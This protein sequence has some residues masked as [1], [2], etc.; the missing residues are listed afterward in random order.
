MLTTGRSTSGNSRRERR[1]TAP[2]PRMSSSS[3]ITV[4]KTGRRTERSEIIMRRISVA[5]RRGRG[6]RLVRTLFERR[7]AVGGRQRPI[8]DA[9]DGA[10]RGAVAHLLRAFDDHLF[11][12]FH[13]GEDL[14]GA[15]L[16]A[17]DAHF[18]TL[19]LAVGD[20]V[21]ELLLRFGRQRFLWDD[22]RGP[23]I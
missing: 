1:V 5:Q 17:A 23:V 15:G 16:A 4:A 14:D 18:A 21:H 6:A 7:L 3:D 2:I 22:E 11:A 12:R 8:L 13:A 19:H 10:Y 20:H 9:F